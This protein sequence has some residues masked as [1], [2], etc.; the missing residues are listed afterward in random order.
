MKQNKKTWQRQVHRLIGAAGAVFVTFSVGLPMAA[1]A[2]SQNYSVLDD[3]AQPGMLM[4]VMANQGVVEQATNK[5]A[6]LLVGVYT[7]EPTVMQGRRRRP[8]RRGG[9]GGGC[10]CAAV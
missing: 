2:A 10:S 6:A 4:S 7:P 1:L 8:A 5:N 9:K 3:K